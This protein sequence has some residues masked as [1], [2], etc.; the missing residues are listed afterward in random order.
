MISPVNSYQQ[1]YRFGVSIGGNDPSDPSVA[2]AAATQEGQRKLQ[3]TANGTIGASALPTSQAVNGNEKG[4]NAA[5][6]RSEAKRD[7]GG[8][9]FEGRGK[10][11]N[12][13][14]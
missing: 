10:I 12:I 11:I 1:S 7:N 2:A 9:N 14:A 8:A 6:V 3:T 4:G 13:T 5:N